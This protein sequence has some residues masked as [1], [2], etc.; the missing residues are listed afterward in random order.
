MTHRSTV[1]FIRG[2]TFSSP[3]RIFTK[4]NVAYVQET[5]IF[6]SYATSRCSILFYDSQYYTPTRLHILV[7]SVAFYCINA[8]NHA[9]DSERVCDT[10]E[11]YIDWYYANSFRGGPWEINSL[12]VI[13]TLKSTC[14][15]LRLTNMSS[16]FSSNSEAD[17]L[18]VNH[19]EMFPQDYSLY[20]PLVG[21]NM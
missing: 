19:E 10:S 5:L 7:C 16:R 6:Y 8:T 18:L 1:I 17:A 15:H 2:L 12:C 11:R 3:K 14:S 4:W 20:I 9:S 21:L 13:I